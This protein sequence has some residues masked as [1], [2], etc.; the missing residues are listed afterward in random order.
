MDRGLSMLWLTH[1][2]MLPRP[3][4]TLLPF[5]ITL[6]IILVSLCL[7]ILCITQVIKRSR[8]KYDEVNTNTMLLIYQGQ[9]LHGSV[10]W[11]IKSED[12]KWVGFRRLPGLTRTVSTSRGIS[13]TSTSVN[14][15]DADQKAQCVKSQGSCEVVIPRIRS[16]SCQLFYSIYHFLFSSVILVKYRV[17]THIM[18][19]WLVP[20]SLG[21]AI[22]TLICKPP[23]LFPP[24]LFQHFCHRV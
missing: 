14:N 11:L 6:V 23:L 18:A 1:C 3:A 22:A 17:R 10:L 24:N 5:L 21:H 19:S 8:L 2:V 4:V 20:K 7:L 15:E 13:M 16:E 12:L 9:G